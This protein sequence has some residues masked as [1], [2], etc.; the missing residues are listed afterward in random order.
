MKFDVVGYMGLGINYTPSHLIDA[1]K[2][3]DRFYISLTPYDKLMHPD[4]VAQLQL[5]D[6][7]KK[8]VAEVAKSYMS[9]LPTSPYGK[10]N[11]SEEKRESAISRW[12]TEERGVIRKRLQAALTPEQMATFDRIILRTIVSYQLASPALCEYLELSGQQ[13]AELRRMAD[14][15]KRRSEQAARQAGAKALAVLTPEQRAR[16]RE[17]ELDRLFDRLVEMTVSVVPQTGPTIVGV[18]TNPDAGL[19]GSIALDEAKQS[20]GVVLDDPYPDFSKEEVQAALGLTEAQR[21]QVRAILGDCS[22]L[23]EKLVRETMKLSPEERSKPRGAR[24]RGL[25]EHRFRLRK[26]LAGRG[27][28]V[29]KGT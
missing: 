22:T 26:A 29:A 16:L 18:G 28:K 27:R 5:T 20:Y 9:D 13:I 7:Q 14:E 23:K 4:I 15:S 21:Q 8:K 24:Q 11:L 3:G 6:E 1:G 17:E 12:H 25:S 10:K 19:I 2:P